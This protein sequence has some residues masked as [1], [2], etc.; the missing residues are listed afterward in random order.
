VTE[1]EMTVRGKKVRHL[2]EEDARARVDRTDQI[3]NFPD[4]ATEREWWRKNTVSEKFWREAQ[5]L[6]DDELP[7][8]R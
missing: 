1:A 6:S 4:E 8:V 5:P 2:D 7:P 3:P